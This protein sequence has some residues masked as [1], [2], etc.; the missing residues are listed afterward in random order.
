MNKKALVTGG[1]RGLGRSLCLALAKKYSVIIHYKNSHKEAVSLQNQLIKKG[2]RAEIIQGDFSY[3][4]GVKSFALEFQKRFSYIDLLINNVGNYFF[5]SF[6]ETELSV[7]K[8]LMQENFYAPFSLV[9]S[10]SDSLW[11]RSGQIINIG[12]GG[13]EAKRA[14]TRTSPYTLSKL[15]LWMF[16]KSLA[17]ELAPNVRV[18]MLSPGYLEGSIDSP[19]DTNKIP[20][21]RLGTGEE[22]AH[23]L[24]FLLDNPYIT[25]QNLEI[26]GGVRL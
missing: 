2:K 1:A 20:L 19:K 13:L 21:K 8:R 10:F 4:E 6:L 24:E 11:S 16:T 23:A 3:E 22:V 9:Q 5:G 7:L 25:G 18:N 12:M 26:T 17:K 15:C 14:D